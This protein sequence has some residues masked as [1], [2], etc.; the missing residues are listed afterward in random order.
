MNVLRYIHYS[1]TGVYSQ[2]SSSNLNSV[3]IP[4]YRFTSLNVS[5][6][7]VSASYLFISASYGD[8]STLRKIMKIVGMLK[9]I[10]FCLFSEKL[11]AISL[12]EFYNSHG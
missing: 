4:Y 8:H 1:R 12:S 10:K 9:F 11:F 2:S 5:A 7:D 3:Y 6:S